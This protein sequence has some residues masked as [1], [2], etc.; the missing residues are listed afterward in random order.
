MVS[1]HMLLLNNNSTQDENERQCSYNDHMNE[2]NVPINTNDPNNV[3]SSLSGPTSSSYARE[4]I[5]LS[6][7]V[8]LKD[9]IMV[10]MPKLVGFKPAKK[11]YRP[12]SN[13]ISANT[14]GKKK[15]AELSS[16][17][18]NN[19]NPF[20]ALNSIEDDDY[21][22]TNDGNSKSDGKGYLNVAHGSYSNTPI[23]E[24]IDKLESQI[25]NGKLTFVD[26][27]KKPLYKVVT[28]GNE[29]SESEVEAVF[30]VTANLMASTSL[31]GGSDSTNCLLEQWRGTK[32]DDDYDPYKDDLYESHDISEYL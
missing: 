3:S 10:A 22:G 17:K 20:Y 16:Q 21:L 2:C 1:Y 32:R 5:E 28:K 15:Q 27:D 7:D 30:D 11:V 29:D 24:K 4:M 31:K 23:I 26:D 13:K 8:E 18:V 14:S 19:S 9:I 6:S 12:V 25:L